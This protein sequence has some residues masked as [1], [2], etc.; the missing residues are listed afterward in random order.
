MTN[1]VDLE[2]LRNRVFFESATRDDRFVWRRIVPVEDVQKNLLPANPDLTQ[3]QITE[4]GR[5]G[6]IYGV[7]APRW[8]DGFNRF[9]I[10]D[11]AHRPADRDGALCTHCGH[12]FEE[13]RSP[14][15]VKKAA[16]RRRKK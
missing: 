4:L 8:A 9:M 14:A 12:A 3:D 5:V 2:E 1:Y 13:P 7:D 6:V 10:V 11:C 15:P 16:A